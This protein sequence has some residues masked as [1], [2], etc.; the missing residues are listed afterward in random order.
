[1]SSESER[2]IAIAS[3]TPSTKDAISAAIT[4]ASVTA[5]ST[6]VMS[7]RL[8]AILTKLGM[9]KGGIPR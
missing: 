9:A 4:R 7:T 6:G 5:T 8:L 1:L 3:A 2:Y